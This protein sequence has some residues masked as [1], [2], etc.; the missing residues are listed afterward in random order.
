MSLEIW[1]EPYADEATVTSTWTFSRLP[2]GCLSQLPYCTR[3][4]I[5]GYAY[6]SIFHNHPRVPSMIHSPSM[7]PSIPSSS[8]Y[9]DAIKSIIISPE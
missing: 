4:F 6:D 5:V 8:N 7:C 3:H 9:A 2:I 1:R